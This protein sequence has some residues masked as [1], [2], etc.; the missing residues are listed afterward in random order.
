M[1]RR[2]IYAARANI[3]FSPPGA[4]QIE[5][6]QSLSATVLMQNGYSALA[7]DQAPSDAYADLAEL[8]VKD[9]CP[10]CGRDKHRGR[11]RK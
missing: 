5:T 6:R 4:D 9:L 2:Q 7:G 1:R 3:P 11:C 10:R 8:L